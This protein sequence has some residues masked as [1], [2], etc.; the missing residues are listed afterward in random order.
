ILLIILEVMAM[1]NPISVS[2][3]KLSGNTSLA[4]CI[5]ALARTGYHVTDFWLCKYCTEPNPPMLRTD[6]RQW[7]S[8]ASRLF[9]Q[10][11]ITVGQA[12]AH[13][14]HPYQIHEDFT[15]D[16]PLQ[17]HYDC[18]EASNMLGCRRLIF[19]P[20]QRWYRMTQESDRQRVLDINVEWFR[21]LLPTA[22][23]YDVELHIENL[24]DHKHVQKE[25]DPIFPFSEPE[26]LL[27]V[28]HKLDHPL[29]RICLDT[30]HANINAMDVPSMIRKFGP[31]L[32]SLHL[33]DNYG[34]I[35]PIYEDL[36]LFPSYGRLPWEE[37][38]SALKEIGYSGT[39]NM[40]PGGELGRLPPA[41]REIQMRA[42]REIME[43]MR[44]IY[45]NTDT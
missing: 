28:V 1:D 6:W 41:L 10:A 16:L 39:L 8:E 33:N 4:G 37:I 32:G 23:K 43:T 19:H 15:Y 18:I 12:H 20:V 13:W 21:A 44:E 7:V 30:G 34:K 36:H 29:M 25:G 24:F 22:E 26:D 17:V 35:G 40:E 2:A 42:A 45:A 27:Y 3:A 5:E 11:G 38:F 14:N 31:L 9:Q